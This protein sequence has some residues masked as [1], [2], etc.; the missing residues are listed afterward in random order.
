MKRTREDDIFP[1]DSRL[2]KCRRLVGGAGANVIK[3]AEMTKN[4][5]R[6]RERIR[7]NKNARRKRVP[8]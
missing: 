4:G 3:S 6:M 7:K 2:M 1:K 5:K 8:N